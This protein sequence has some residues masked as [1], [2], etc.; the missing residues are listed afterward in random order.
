MKFFFVYFLAGYRV[1]WPLHWPL[2]ILRDVWIRTRR[3][4]VASRRATN[5]ATHLPTQPPISLLSHPSPYL[6]THLPELSHS[7]PYLATHL[8]ELSHPSPYLA[9]HLPNKPP[10]SLLLLCHPSPYFGTG[11]PNLSTHLPGMKLKIQFAKF[12][13]YRQT[14]VEED[15]FPA[16]PAPYLV[17]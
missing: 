1:C 4:V 9:T 2:C 3:A 15:M 16:L 8:P 11:H 7:S 17:P 6:P 13:I 14:G 10:I 12:C 5:V